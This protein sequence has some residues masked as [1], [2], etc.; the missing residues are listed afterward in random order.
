MA[1][2]DVSI[3]MGTL[4]EVNSIGKQGLKIV[5]KTRPERQEGENV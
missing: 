5:G 3:E 1:D 2:R 4:S